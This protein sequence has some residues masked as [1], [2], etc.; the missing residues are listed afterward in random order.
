[1][2]RSPEGDEARVTLQAD[3]LAAGL[4]EGSPQEHVVLGEHV[5]VLLAEATDEER[6]PLDVCEQ[7]GEGSAYGLGHLWPGKPDRSG[8]SPLT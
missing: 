4:L 6:R 1:M 7:K 8:E 3:S 5:A 2:L